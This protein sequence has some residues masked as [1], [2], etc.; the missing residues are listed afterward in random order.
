MTPATYGTARP[1]QRAARL[2]ELPGPTYEVTARIVDQTALDG[3]ALDT[4]AA[5]TFST[6]GTSGSNSDPAATGATGLSSA[7]RAAAAARA[8]A[9]AMA[10]DGAATGSSTGGAGSGGLYPGPGGLPLSLPPIPKSYLLWGLAAVAAVVVVA[11]A[12]K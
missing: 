9:A 3:S 5:L 12:R 8:V 1:R 2:G 11:G 7:D 6:D 10:R 4:P